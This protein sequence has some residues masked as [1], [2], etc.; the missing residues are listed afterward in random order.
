MD[1]P[2]VYL[3]AGESGRDEDQVKRIRLRA[4]FPGQT[5]F[6]ELSPP[7]GLITIIAFVVLAI[8]ATVF[9]WWFKS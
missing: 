5:R 6:P 3:D 7:P 2:S 9:V 4:N 8:V 1:S